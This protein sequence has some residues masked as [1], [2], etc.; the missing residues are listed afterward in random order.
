MTT[1][2][3]E[4]LFDLGEPS[5]LP[6]PAFE[7]YGKLGFPKPHGERPWIY[8]NFV[9][10]IDGIASF[11]G[12]H[13]TGGDLDNVSQSGDCD[14]SRAVGGCPVADL[15]KSVTAPA[16]RAPVRQ[17]SASVL[18]ATADDCDGIRDLAG[19]YRSRT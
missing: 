17:N 18:A 19:L 13:A 15:A 4:V 6:D 9:Q 5:P 3:F 12:E 8:A 16:A 10:S 2:D 1:P 7:R 14:R 11:L